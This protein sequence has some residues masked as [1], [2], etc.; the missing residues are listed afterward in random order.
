MGMVIGN[1]NGNR[2]Y[3]SIFFVQFVLVVCPIICQHVFI[4]FF[5]GKHFT[6]SEANVFN[7]LMYSWL[8]KL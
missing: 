5:R 2:N 4:L 3:L 1:G 6:I 8:G 7:C